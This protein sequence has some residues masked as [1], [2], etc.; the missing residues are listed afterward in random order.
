MVRINEGV[1]P[2]PLLTEILQSAY[3]AVDPGTIEGAVAPQD[4]PYFDALN[5]PQHNGEFYEA[6]L[7][8]AYTAPLP[9][10]Y[11]APLSGE[12]IVLDGQPPPGAILLGP[13]EDDFVNQIL[14]EVLGTSGN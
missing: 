10:A 5:A 1:D 13:V 8:E 7:P 2:R 9:E 14:N 6:P 12:V 11:A 3:V 4:V